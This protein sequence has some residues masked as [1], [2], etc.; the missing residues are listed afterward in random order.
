M[1]KISLE[2]LMASGAFEEPKEEQN[3]TNDADN[4]NTNE[5]SIQKAPLE[6]LLEKKGRGGKTAVIICGFEGSEEELKSLGKTLKSKCGV[7][8]SVRGGEILIQGNVRDKVMS[9]LNEM[10]YKTKR[11]GG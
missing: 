6:V 4:E 9:L 1:K 7:G 8:G 11:I 3:Q 5:S 2:E 10:G